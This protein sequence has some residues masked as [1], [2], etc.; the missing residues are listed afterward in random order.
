MKKQKKI[1]VAIAACAVTIVAAANVITVFQQEKELNE[2]VSLTVS[3]VEGLARGEYGPDYPAAKNQRCA[4]GEIACKEASNP[5]Y[6]CTIGYF[7]AD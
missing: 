2:W 7:C 4:N 1:M 6:V 3:D 5:A